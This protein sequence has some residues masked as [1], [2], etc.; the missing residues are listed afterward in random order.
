MRNPI[1][2]GLAAL[3]LLA[4]GC[5]GP[6]VVTTP[7]SAPPASSAAAPAPTSTRPSNAH[8]ANA[9]DFAADSGEQTGYYFVS[10]SGRWA[11][12]I[13]P[14]LRAG[15]QNAQPPS[16]LGIQAAPDEV[17]GPDGRPAAPTAVVVDRTGGPHFAA[18]P[19]PGFT[20]KT[21]QAEKLPFNRILAVAGFRCNVQE[22]TG[23]SCLSEASGEGFT[24]AAD[25][26]VPVY[27][28][29]PADAP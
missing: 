14:R 1:R 3:T 4:A 9:Y 10:P 29:V 16:A 26:Y 20:L 6:T 19:S 11:C 5:S 18:V 7:D 13:I 21:E 23:I 8:L 24:F 2:V 12:A 22:A 27:T 15:C 28:D 17:P 25:S